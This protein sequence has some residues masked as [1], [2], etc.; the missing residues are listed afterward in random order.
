MLS[1]IRG[2]ISQG[3]IHLRKIYLKSKLL[4]LSQKIKP[5]LSPESK[6][7][8]LQLRENGVVK[9]HKTFT[10]E[11]VKLQDSFIKNKICNSSTWSVNDITAKKFNIR[12]WQYVSLT[13]EDV[14][15]IF[16]ESEIIPIICAYYKS[17]AYFRRIPF[18]KSQEYIGGKKQISAV[19]H[20]DA[21]INQIGVQVLLNDI[22]EKETH[23]V[24]LNGSHKRFV[25][26][27]AR[28]NLTSPNLLI[29]EKKLETKYSKT[30]LVGMK[31]SVFIFDNGNGLHK[32]NMIN[33]TRRDILQVSFS[34]GDYQVRNIDKEKYPRKLKNNLTEKKKLFKESIKFII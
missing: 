34:R 30:K 3:K 17:N 5:E 14:F 10:N 23:M 24:Y 32:G 20:M 33:N 25:G 16:L 27:Y 19:Y 18:M 12:Y 11:A 9:Y 7:C 26:N 8:L 22:T 15:R 21:N 1:N 28:P 29:K 6:Q 2:K 13:N 31:G 4:L